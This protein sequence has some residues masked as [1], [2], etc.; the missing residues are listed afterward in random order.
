MWFGFG[1]T[2][3]KN[4]HEDGSLKDHSLGRGVD[5]TYQLTRLISKK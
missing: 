4:H 3:H 1:E 2:W 5:W